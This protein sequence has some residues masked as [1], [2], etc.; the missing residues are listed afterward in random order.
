MTTHVVADGVV[1]K[2]KP[3]VNEMEVLLVNRIPD[4]VR[5]YK[6]GGLDPAGVN[7]TLQMVSEGAIITE[8]K[9]VVVVPPKPKPEKFAL[10]ADLGIIT[11][12]EDYVHT[13]HMDSFKKKHQTWRKKAFYFYNDALTDVNFPSPSRV[14][15]PGDKLSVRAFNQVVSGTTTSKER[16]EFL[17]SQHVVLVG[18]Q[19]A[20]LV[21]DQKRDQLP[22]GYWYV[23]FDE[24]E[25]LWQDPG[26]DHGVPYVSAGSDGGFR[27]GLGHFEYDW[28]DGHVLLCFCDLPKSD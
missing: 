5:R 3:T 9:M 10:L 20:S 24:K 11:V 25:R 6:E 12:P 19:G 2:R 18:A 26:G 21:F 13:M 14:L 4:L 7:T 17:K 28:Y 27:F 22:K 15:K 16:M 1:A 23:S 8:S